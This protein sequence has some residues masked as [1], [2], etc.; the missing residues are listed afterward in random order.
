MWEP[1]PSQEELD[2]IGITLADLGEAEPIEVW[3]EN[4]NAAQLFNAMDTQWRHNMSGPAGLDYTALD[5]TAGWL[6]LEIKSKRELFRQIRVMEEEARKQIA[7]T[8]SA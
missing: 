4:W 2:L 7:K 5:S 6:E 3:P 1:G 8:N